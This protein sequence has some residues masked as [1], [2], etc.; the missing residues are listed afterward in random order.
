MNDER[1]TVPATRRL[2]LSDRTQSAHGLV[3][4]LAVGINAYDKV[5]GWLLHY[6]WNRVALVPVFV[7]LAQW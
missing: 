7:F 3:R 4:V 2:T 6:L 1:M 5:S